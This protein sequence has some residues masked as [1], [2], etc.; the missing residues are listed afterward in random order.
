MG[1]DLLTDEGLELQSSDVGVITPYTK[2]LQAMQKQLDGLGSTFAG[3][4][5]G[6]VEWFQGQ[7]R[8]VVIMST[9]R[10]SRLADG[11]VVPDG[12]DRRPIGFVADP[13][14]LNVAI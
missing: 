2:Q 11:S 9:V 13:K 8:S 14:R 10:C 12:A 1:I 4:E 3:V 5:C 7:E 6:T